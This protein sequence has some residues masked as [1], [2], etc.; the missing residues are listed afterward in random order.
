MGNGDPQLDLGEP[1]G[2]LAQQPDLGFTCGAVKDLDL[3][4]QQA[5]ATASLAQKR[6]AALAGCRFVPKLAR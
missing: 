1:K 2:C 5:L 4:G 3:P 6:P